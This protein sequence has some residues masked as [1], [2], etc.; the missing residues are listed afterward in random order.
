[1]SRLSATVILSLFFLMGG[2]CGTNAVQTDAPEMILKPNSVEGFLTEPR[3]PR[4]TDAILIGYAPESGAPTSSKLVIPIFVDK[5]GIPRGPFRYEGE[6]APPAQI[7]M[8]IR[9]KLTT[10]WLAN[11]ERLMHSTRFTPVHQPD[12]DRW[13]IKDCRPMDEAP[14]WAVTFASEWSDGPA[15]GQPSALVL[16]SNRPRTSA[17]MQSAHIPVPQEENAVQ[18][19]LSIPFILIFEIMWRLAE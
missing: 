9:M 16:P 15:V 14:G 8:L 1:M 12:G 11:G 2:G 13:I 10:L 4:L 6:H 7:Q 3:S 19:A 17:E 18:T 5:N